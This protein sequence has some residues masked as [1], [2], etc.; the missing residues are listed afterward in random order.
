MFSRWLCNNKA[1]QLVDTH[2]HIHEASDGGK[3]YVHD[4][5]RVGGKKDPAVL[6]AD[7]HDAG[8][9]K[10]ICVGCT[11]ADSKLAVDFAQRQQGV[12]ASIGIHPHEAKLHNNPESKAEFAALATANRVVAVGECGLDYFYNHSPKADQT[13]LL[14][15]QL[16]LALDHDLPV[17]FHV[18][19]AFDDFWPVFA[20]FPGVR[21]V[22]HSFTDSMSNMD[23]ATE[24]GLHIGVNGIATFTKDTEQRK[25][26]MAIPLQKLLLETDAP[27]LTP[28]PVRGTLNEP[29]NVRYITQFLAELRGEDEATLAD[30]TTRNATTLFGL[31]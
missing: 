7:A 18:R 1:M 25:V 15:F 22:L 19:E 28:A 17:I 26:F 16:Q 29:K 14:E 24:A 8:V 5:W 10:L 31:E 20:N 11:L 2:C 23:K 6:A 27:F 4:K 13:A 3:G 12:W 9:A 30:A 21:G